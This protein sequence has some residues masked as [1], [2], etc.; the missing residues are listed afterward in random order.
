MWGCLILHQLNKCCAAIFKGPTEAWQYHL[1][2]TVKLS[3]MLAGTAHFVAARDIAAGEQLCIS[4]I[5]A[6]MSVRAR[7]RQLD[8][9]YGFR[10][11]CEAC[12]EEA[13]QQL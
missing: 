1:N 5:D 2:I 13:E 8:W 12:T 6:S 3:P 11:S 10:C 9:G 4:Y 7:Q